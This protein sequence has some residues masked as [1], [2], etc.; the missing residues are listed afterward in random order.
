MSAMVRSS[1]D[2]MV[3]ERTPSEELVRGVVLVLFGVI[4]LTVPAGFMTL[5][6]KILGMVALIDGALAFVGMFRQRA[7]GQSLWALAVEGIAGVGG[8]LLTLWWPALTAF[9]LLTILGVWAFVTGGAEFFS[10][11]GEETT[12]GRK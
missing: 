7:H 12:R 1:E 11:L 6:L 3:R 9:V 4:V 8:G 10:A 2:H 5:V